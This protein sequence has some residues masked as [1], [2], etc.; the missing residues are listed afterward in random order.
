M[1]C[2][3][4]FTELSDS[5]NFCPQCGAPVAATPPLTDISAEAAPSADTEPHAA[6]PSPAEEPAEVVAEPI[7]PEPPP[8]EVTE[9]EPASSEAP[10]EPSVAA[11]PPARPVIVQPI[12]EPPAEKIA[13]EE[14]APPAHPV[15]VPSVATGERPAAKVAVETPPPTAAPSSYVP[16]QKRKRNVGRIILGA[17][18]LLFG[19]G[20]AMFYDLPSRLG[21]LGSPAKEMLSDVPLREAG[22]AVL[23]DFEAGRQPS[24]GIHVYV[25]PYKGRDYSLAYVVLDQSQGYSY[26]E[27]GYGNPITAAFTI[28]ANSKQ[29]EA[30][31][32]NRVAVEFRTADKATL[33]VMT[34]PVFAIQQYAAG[35]IDKKQ[36]YAHIDGHGDP[37]RIF[38]QQYGMFLGGS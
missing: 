30:A 20:A 23:Q 38:K 27:T 33:F 22:A 24:K 16:A 37:S 2:T 18:V 4:C 28:V 34:A 26:V 36:F 10:A 29:V 12:V 13:I 25:L 19:A 21:L 17:I 32:I 1:H 31:Q 35:V 9:P 3:R 6:A 7:T 8:I 5:A 14:P 11:E 15:I